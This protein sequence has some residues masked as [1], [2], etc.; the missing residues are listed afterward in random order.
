MNNNQIA[1]LASDGVEQRVHNTLREPALLVLVHVNHLA[2]VRR[3]LREMQA[4]REIHQVQNILLEAAAPEPDARAQELRAH[5]RIAAD[6]VRNLVDIRARRLADRAERID[7]RDA[8]REHR[9]RRELAQLARPQAD[10]EYALARDPVRV[11]GR[12]R[13]ARALAL[14]RLQR[15]D[16]HPVRLEQVVDRGALGEELGVG[17]DVEPAARLRV[18]LEDGPHRFGGAAGHGGFLDD[19]LGGFGDLGD[20]SGGKFNVAGDAC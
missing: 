7:G 9:V 15:A 8:L 4:L 14:G 11:H 20:A 10:R 13:G 5:T 2:P 18:G 16:E 17:E 1:H 19:D 6:G 3:D 12:E